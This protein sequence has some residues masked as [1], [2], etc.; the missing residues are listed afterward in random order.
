MARRSIFLISGMVLCTALF[1]GFFSMGCKKA[2]NQPSSTAVQSDVAKPAPPAT[3]VPPPPPPKTPM[4]EL[5]GVARS[6]KTTIEAMCVEKGKYLSA[7]PGTEVF[8]IPSMSTICGFDENAAPGKTFLVLQFGGKGQRNFD[9]D[10]TKFVSLTQG[11]YLVRLDEHSWLSDASGA[12]F[13]S[14]LLKT[15]KGPTT[16]S[17]EVP[18]NAAGLVWHYGKKQYQLEPHPVEIADAATSPSSKSEK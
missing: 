11:K 10:L 17:F 2:E 4:G 15:H 18:S 14:G 3:P 7:K 16:L 5:T 1:E 12:K 9:E 13:K 6:D 8:T